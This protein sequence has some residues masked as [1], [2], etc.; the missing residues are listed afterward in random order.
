MGNKDVPGVF[1]SQHGGQGQALGL[2]GWQVF[3]TV[4]GHVQLA[5]EKQPFDLCDKYAQPHAGQGRISVDVTL[6]A[7]G[8][9]LEVHLRMHGAQQ[10]QNL[11]G[12]AQ[13][14]AAAAGANLYDTERSHYDPSS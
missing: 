5:V 10:R 8:N 14:Q 1:A 11:F 4:H 13:C 6:S 12:L 9:N 2:F 7:D 3:K